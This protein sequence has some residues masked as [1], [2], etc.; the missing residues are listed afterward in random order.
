METRKQTRTLETRRLGTNG[1]EVSALG[2]GCMGRS[3]AYGPATEKQ[4]AI[5]LLHAAHER[6]VTFFDT[7]EAYPT[8]GDLAREMCV[9]ARTLQ[10]RLTDAGSSFQQVVDETRHE[11]ARHYLEQS[12]IE[13]H[14]AAYLLGYED[15]NSFF[16]AFRAW[17]GTTPGQYVSALGVAGGVGA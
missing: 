9:S 17:E 15:A 10:R 12:A 13:L 11:L 2:L 7:A 3:F 16:R 1:P 6:G 14:E 4:Q 5:A 8:L